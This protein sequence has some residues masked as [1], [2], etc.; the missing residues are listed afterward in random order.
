MQGITLHDRFMFTFGYFRRVIALI[1][2]LVSAVS[3]TIR[4]F[5]SFILKRLK[6][7]TCS[8][9]KNIFCFFFCVVMFVTNAYSQNSNYEGWKKIDAGT[10]TNS[11]TFNGSHSVLLAIHDE[12]GFDLIENIFDYIDDNGVQVD[13]L[14][15]SVQRDITLTKDRLFYAKNFKGI[16]KICL[17]GHGASI[18]LSSSSKN[19]LE[20]LD[21]DEVAIY[22][23][24]FDNVEIEQYRTG[25]FYSE[26]CSS[27]HQMP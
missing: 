6:S 1:L 16:S 10:Q 18:G 14:L 4:E 3:R 25:N 26:S 20:F 9:V 11:L 5:S 13:S 24:T 7:D 12:S 21:F 2:V 27:E 23:L 17:L 19:E 22:D 15:V 8:P